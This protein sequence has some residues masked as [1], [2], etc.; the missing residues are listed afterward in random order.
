MENSV[1]RFLVVIVLSA[2]VPL[3]TNV[4]LSNGRYVCITGA[5]YLKI[6]FSDPTATISYKPEHGPS[7]KIVLWQSVFDGPVTIISAH[8]TNVLLCLYDFDVDFRLLRIDTNKVFKPLP[9]GSD[10][11]RILL[12]RPWE[13]EGGSP[14][15][16]QELLNFLQNASPKAFSQQSV[17]VGMRIYR[18]PASLLR[19]LEQQ[20]IKLEK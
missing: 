4:S 16:W 13:I 10:L 1:F 12:A 14:A 19:R 20:G 5:S 17:P 15:D 2:F 9:P 18:T 7:G 8:D 11:N 3:S 6:I